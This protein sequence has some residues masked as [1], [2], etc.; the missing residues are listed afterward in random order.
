MTIVPEFPDVHLAGQPLN[1][2]DVLWRPAADLSGTLAAAFADI[3]TAVQLRRVKVR[4]VTQWLLPCDLPND[5]SPEL[6]LGRSKVLQL[7]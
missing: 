6:S 4:K 3:P 7:L 5:R 2:A 1:R